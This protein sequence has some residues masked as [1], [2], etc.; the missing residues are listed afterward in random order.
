M[1]MSGKFLR[2]LLL[3]VFVA[4]VQTQSMPMEDTALTR[5]SGEEMMETAEAQNPFL[6]R[7]AMK[8]LKERRQQAQARR[9]HHS[10]HSR[11]QPQYEDSNHYG[12]WG[13]YV[14][15]IFY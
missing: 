3:L 11:T 1:E 4:I 12:Y 6:P 2:L 14:S 8:K 5:N 7:F 13:F 10:A 15:I 9:R